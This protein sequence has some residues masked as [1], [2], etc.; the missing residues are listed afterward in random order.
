MRNPR[1]IVCGS[2]NWIDR[3]LIATVIQEHRD[4]HGD[5][6][7]V[8]HGG[9]RGADRIA[10]EEAGRLGIATEAHPADW[11]RYGKPAGHVRNEEMAQAGALKVEAFWDGKSRGTWGMIEVAKRH[12]I[13]YAIHFGKP[14]GASIA[15]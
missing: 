8:V 3:D 2:R 14:D 4:E 5:G 6:L 11:E 13:H 9:A 10:A 15:A 1:V 7:V 12:G